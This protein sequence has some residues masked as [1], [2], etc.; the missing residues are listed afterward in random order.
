M[1]PRIS[2]DELPPDHPTRRAIDAATDALANA[3]VRADAVDPLVTEVVRLR[4][5]QV[6]DCRR[7]GSL[8]SVEATRQGL[9]DAMADKI[10]VHE[11]SDLDPA[12]KVALRLCDAV[13]LTP[14]RVEPTLR[15]DLRAHF[16]DEQIA[17]LLFDVMKWSKQ[18]MLVALRWDAAPWEG[19]QL[20]AFDDDGA[21]LLVDELDDAGNMRGAR[22]LREAVATKAGEG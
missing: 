12:L 17:E 19:R 8:R 4:C 20:I 5:A 1:K 10:A 16:S 7:C 11:T 13:I 15:D 21:P 14:G 18:K 2:S 22:S 9:D 3:A 6:H